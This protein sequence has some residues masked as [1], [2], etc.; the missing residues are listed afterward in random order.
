MSPSDRPFDQNAPT[1]RAF[2]ERRNVLAILGG[3]EPLDR[4]VRDA[5]GETAE[6]TWFRH[7]ASCGRRLSALSPRLVIAHLRDAAGENT[8]AVLR[9]LRT[10]QSVRVVLCVSTD[11]KELRAA[12]GVTM[13]ALVDEVVLIGE[14]D[15]ADAIRRQ[16][17]VVERSSFAAAIE[18]V[19][20]GR[21]S[22]Q[23]Q[24]ALAWAAVRVERHLTVE[25]WANGVGWDR[26]TLSDKLKRCGLPMPHVILSW[27]RALYCAYRLS[28]QRAPIRDVASALRLH[29]A[30][31]VNRL[32]RMRLD[33][34]PARLRDAGSFDTALRAYA[35][36]VGG[37]SD[38]GRPDE[39]PVHFNDSSEVP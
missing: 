12:L 8:A 38:S 13:R 18:H 33:T 19:T 36:V 5:A 29:S 9:D 7:V 28:N 22:E 4:L 24:R 6:V 2:V 10:R 32:V 21:A 16:L 35:R 31:D 25:T 23:A 14:D 26:R 1:V 20:V 30:S 15:V 37:R 3:T 27:H 39:P 17:R 11:P 34:T